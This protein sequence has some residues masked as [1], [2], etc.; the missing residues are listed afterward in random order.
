VDGGTPLARPGWAMPDHQ[1]SQS[2]QGFHRY[3][4]PSAVLE[5]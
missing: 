2:F 1:R 5:P 3:K 4:P